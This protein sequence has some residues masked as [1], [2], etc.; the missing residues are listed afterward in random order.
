MTYTHRKFCKEISVSCDEYIVL[1]QYNLVFTEHVV[2]PCKERF[3]H[4]IC[5]NPILSFNSK[6][7]KKRYFRFSLQKTEVT[8]FAFRRHSEGW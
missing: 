3:S 8:V 6:K 1:V 7:K 2:Q 5:T 4:Q